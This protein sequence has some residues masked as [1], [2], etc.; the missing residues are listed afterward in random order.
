MQPP[1][2]RGYRLERR[3]ATH[4]KEELSKGGGSLWAG[5]LLGLSHRQAKRLW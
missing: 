4:V 3:D 2:R 1:R 5:E